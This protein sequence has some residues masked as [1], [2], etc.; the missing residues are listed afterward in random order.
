MGVYKGV[1]TGEVTYKPVV[2]GISTTVQAIILRGY[3][4]AAAH[5]AR[6]DLV[7]A[8]TDYVVAPVDSLGSED[9]LGGIVLDGVVSESVGL[10]DPVGAAADVLAGDVVGLLDEIVGSPDVALLEQVGLLDEVFNDLTMTVVETEGLLDYSAGTFDT[11]IS[12][13]L[14]VVSGGQLPVYYDTFTNYSSGEDLVGHSTD[15]GVGVWYDSGNPFLLSLNVTGGFAGFDT[16]GAYSN[17]LDHGLGDRFYIKFSEPLFGFTLITGPTSEV[18]DVFNNLFDGESYPPPSGSLYWTIPAGAG[19]WQVSNVYDSIISYTSSLSGEV[20]LLFVGGEILVYVGGVFETRFS[21][22]HSNFD[23]IVLYATDSSAQNVLDYIEVGTFEGH[24]VAPDVSQVENVGLLDTDVVV[25]DAVV[26]VDTEDVSDPVVT[27]SA[28]DVS[29]LFGLLDEPVVGPDVVVNEIVGL[30]DQSFTE[31]MVDTVDV[32]GLVDSSSSEVVDVVSESVGLT[33]GSFAG[34]DG[35]VSES[36]GLSDESIV[37]SDVLAVDNV[38]IVDVHVA[39]SDVIPVDNVGVVDESLFDLSGVVDDVIGVLDP[40]SSAVEVFTSESSGLIDGI[41]PGYG[42]EPS[43]SVG[44]TDVMF[45]ELSVV[46]LDV[47]GLSVVLASVLDTYASSSVGFVDQLEAS[48]NVNVSETVSLIDEH[49]L[50]LSVGIVSLVDAV[51]PIS[52]DLSVIASETLIA[53]DVMEALADVQLADIQSLLDSI[54]EYVAAYEHMGYQLV[55]NTT[56]RNIIVGYDSKVIDGE[57]RGRVQI[58]SASGRYFVLSVTKY[59]IVP[60]VDNTYGKLISE[61]PSDG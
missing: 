59:G 26:V 40:D 27:D 6:M 11:V 22:D 54:L 38:G 51:D 56:G 29:D 41:V 49:V 18:V 50:E 14:I 35:V 52:F 53:T 55:N 57:I 46:P 13:S 2:P 34:V 24:V 58:V 37:A 33:D 16:G 20:V 45:S 47:L 36:V 3:V 9:E 60:M 1:P 43:D 8:G 19:A 48:P 4:S 12:P 42:H 15:D 32:V 23:S 25:D 30:T 61:G 17:A 39:G 21:Y 5:F 10:S 28:H 44:V 31:S 7:L